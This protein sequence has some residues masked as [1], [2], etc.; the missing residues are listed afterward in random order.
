MGEEQ[1]VARHQAWCDRAGVQ[2]PL[3][4]VR[5]ENHD[6]VRLFAGQLGRGDLQSL[7]G[8]GLPATGSLRQAHPDVHAGVAQRQR[9]RVPLTAV[10]EHRDVTPLDDC[11]VR[12]V[13]VE[14][15]CHWLPSLG[16]VVGSELAERGVVGSELAE[17]GVVGSELAERG[18]A[19]QGW[20]RLLR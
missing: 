14:D 2:G 5:G 4:V 6:Q 9:V 18:V 16:G 12:L 10:A 20:Q 15:V 17:R 11:Q 7:A 8:G 1:G 3:H 13:V 19:G